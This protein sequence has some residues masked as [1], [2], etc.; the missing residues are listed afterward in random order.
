MGVLYRG[1]SE[2]YRDVDRM[3]IDLETDAQDLGGSIFLNIDRRS[4]IGRQF[5]PDTAYFFQANSFI[6]VTDLDTALMATNLITWQVR[7]GPSCLLLPFC[8]PLPVPRKNGNHV[9]VDLAERSICW[10]SVWWNFLNSRDLLE[11]CCALEPFHFSLFPHRT[12]TLHP[13]HSREAPS[14]TLLALRDLNPCSILKFLCTWE[15]R[16]VSFLPTCSSCLRAHPS[17]FPKAQLL[18]SFPPLASLFLRS[19]PCSSC[20]D[21]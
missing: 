16:F 6:I 4:Q 5:N 8:F 18:F 3:L 21:L 14:S 13:L 15:L 19:L 17:R 2:F 7:F 1:I 11:P 9:V 20:A 10:F 12:L